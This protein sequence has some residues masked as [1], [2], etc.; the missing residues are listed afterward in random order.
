MNKELLKKFI[1]DSTLK[2]RLI[3]AGLIL[4]LMVFVLYKLMLAPYAAHFSSL[5]GQLKSYQ[6]LL[7]IKLGR[8]RNLGD[9]NQEYSQNEKT[10]Q[11][12]NKRFFTEKEAESF[13]KK[14]PKIV[15]DFGNRV[16]LL[17][18]QL[19]PRFLS[20]S[21]KL[22]KYVLGLNLPKEKDL[23][24]FIK[25]NQEKLDAEGTAYDLLKDA[26]LM[27]PE[28]KRERFRAIWKEAESDDNFYTQMKTRKVDLEAT[29]QGSFKGI[30]S[31][32]AWF[33]EYDKIINLEKVQMRTNQTGIETKFTLTI[34]VI[35]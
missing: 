12:L 9:L 14:L 6:K 3:A 20:R 27:V 1:L 24:K 29:I 11:D 10:L 33:D 30:L 7:D 23:L 18:P 13:M 2:E 34:Y 26:M 19:K 31:L 16:I 28:S 15:S 8:S 21:E 4:L 25:Q 17:K 32:L 35:K 5:H 22:K